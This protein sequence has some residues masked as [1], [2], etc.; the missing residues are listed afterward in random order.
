MFP[1]LEQCVSLV[2][3]RESEAVWI[4][5][6]LELTGIDQFGGLLQNLTMMRASLARNEWD[7][8]VLRVYGHGLDERIH[9]V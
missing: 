5:Q 8:H 2:G 7:R 1:R 6:R 4:D 3:L 9:Q